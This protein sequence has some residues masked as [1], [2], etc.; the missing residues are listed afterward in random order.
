MWLCRAA[1]GLLAFC[2]LAM[3]AAA[4][5]GAYATT[6]G[7]IERGQYRHKMVARRLRGAPSFLALFAGQESS[8]QIVRCL[9]VRHAAQR[10][11]FEDSLGD[12]QSAFGVD[13]G[14]LAQATQPNCCVAFAELLPI[15]ARAACLAP[16]RLGVD[17]QE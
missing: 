15:H 11:T 14:L 7:P 16:A 10:P 2:N 3:L 17:S 8:L 1:F 5:A 12:V 6:L 4:C 13:G 9:A